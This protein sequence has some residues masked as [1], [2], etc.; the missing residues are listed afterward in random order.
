MFEFPKQERVTTLVHEA[1]TRIPHLGRHYNNDLGQE[2][3]KVQTL[4]DTAPSARSQKTFL[5]GLARHH[6]ARAEDTIVKQILGDGSISVEEM[7]HLV[8]VRLI[9]TEL[10]NLLAQGVEEFRTG[11]NQRRH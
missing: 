11:V 5:L 4:L 3:T 9:C 2:F 7:S 10:L 1:V 8:R 6:V